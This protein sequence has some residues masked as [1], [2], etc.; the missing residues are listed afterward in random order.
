MEEK[1]SLKNNHIS[2]RISE[3]Q[4]SRLKKNIQKDKLSLSSFVRDLINNEIK[5]T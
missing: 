4:L 5:N 3:E 2:I 1:K